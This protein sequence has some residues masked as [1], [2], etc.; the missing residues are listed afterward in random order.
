MGNIERGIKAN[1]QD[2]ALMGLA[3][4][5][6]RAVRDHRIAGIESRRRGRSVWK[7]IGRVG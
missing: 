4:W 3:R 5:L 6:G 7:R 1:E 2:T